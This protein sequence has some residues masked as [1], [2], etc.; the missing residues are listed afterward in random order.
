MFD[1][2]FNF[3]NLDAPY[4]VIFKECMLLAWWKQD[5]IRKQRGVHSRYRL[6]CSQAFKITFKVSGCI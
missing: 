1:I 6:K 3:V 5:F 2:T 4:V